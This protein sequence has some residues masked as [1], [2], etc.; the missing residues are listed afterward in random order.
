MSPTPKWVAF[1]LSGG[2]SHSGPQNH[3][4]T[5][6]VGGTHPKRSL[7]QFVEL[8]SSQIWWYHRISPLSL[9]F[10]RFESWKWRSWHLES[11]FKH[12]PI[13]IW[14]FQDHSWPST[15]AKSFTI[16]IW[17][18]LLLASIIY[19]KYDKISFI[20][21][22]FRHP[23]LAYSTISI[24]WINM[25]IDLSLMISQGSTEHFTSQPG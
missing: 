21:N 5:W 11:K 7:F 1:I 2:S 16:L 17:N 20:W 10:Q 25:E 18:I 24:A 15:R 23:F 4:T 6:W 8:Y 19:L 14:S 12:W 13:H 3:A 9:A 22:I